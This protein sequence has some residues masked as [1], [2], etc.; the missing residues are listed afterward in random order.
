P[1]EFA[2]LSASCMVN[3]LKWTAGNGPSD[4]ANWEYG[5][6]CPAAGRIAAK[7]GLRR[8]IQSAQEAASH[9]KSF[10][11]DVKAALETRYAQ[12][13]QF[14]AGVLKDPTQPVEQDKDLQMPPNYAAFLELL[15]KD[16]LSGLLVVTLRVP[17]SGDGVGMFPWWGLF[18]DTDVKG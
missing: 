8:W 7:S 6:N 9:P 18:D 3:D 16:P 13:V 14:R 4:P 1:E 11:E 10:D 12:L 17:G 5:P 15:G 2:N